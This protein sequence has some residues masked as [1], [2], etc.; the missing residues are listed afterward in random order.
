MLRILLALLRVFKTIVECGGFSAA[1]AELN[2]SQ[3]T[4][5]NELRRCN[6]SRRSRRGHQA[7]G[8]HKAMDRR[9]S[10]CGCKSII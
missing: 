10:V 7:A 3:S 2:I 6:R 5:S 1:Q 4:I 8:L 9:Q